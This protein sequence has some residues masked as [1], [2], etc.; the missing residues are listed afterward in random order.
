MFGKI[1]YESSA[2]I[3]QYSSPGGWYFVTL[4]EEMAKEIRGTIQWQEEGWGRIKVIAKVNN[5]QWKTSIKGSRRG[6]KDLT[7]SSQWGFSPVNRCAVEP[8]RL[9]AF[10]FFAVN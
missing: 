2:E 10:V 5:N 4:P 9:Y 7:Q 3:W 6:R 1:E 8:L